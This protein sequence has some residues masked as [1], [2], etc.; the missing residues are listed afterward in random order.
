MPEMTL[1]DRE[2]AQTILNN[3]SHELVSSHP[4]VKSCFSQSTRFAFHGIIKLI[5]I[6]V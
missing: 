2:N 5:F 3:F 6:I 4:I 1:M